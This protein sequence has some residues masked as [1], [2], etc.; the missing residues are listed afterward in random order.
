MTGATLH[1]KH[2]QALRAAEFGL[3]HKRR[4]LN[5]RQLTVKIQPEKSAVGIQQVQKGTYDSTGESGGLFK[6]HE[7]CNRRGK[8][9]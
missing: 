6:V 9:H 7:T 5:S 3:T 1:L 2:R 8:V 4:N